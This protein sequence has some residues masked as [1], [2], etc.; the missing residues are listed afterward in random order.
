MS[1]PPS[2]NVVILGGTSGVGFETAARFAEQGDRV[3]IMGRNRRRGDSALNGLTSR[4][5]GAD[6]RFLP[7]DAA[8]AADAVRGA[9]AANAALGSIDVLVCST[10]T[11]RLPRLLHKME[12]AAIGG[13]LTEIAL[14]PLHMTQAV[15]GHMRAVGRG[16]I[17]L[18]A[19]DAAKVPTPGEAVIGAAMA[20]ICMFARTA[21]VEAKRDGVRINVLTPSLIADTPGA[22]AIATEPFAAKLFAK[23]AQNAHLGV[24]V[25]A[26]LAE[27]ALFLAGPGS[28]RMTGQVLSVNG[29]ISVA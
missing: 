16:S 20:A 12:P 23:A 22:A 17:I 7:V 25:P 28:A 4:V 1:D 27:L 14:P 15:L 9:D 24:A 6:V 21:A 13:C 19:S 2:N 3:A 26:D 18:I 5:P 11:S 10:S 29:G 8:D